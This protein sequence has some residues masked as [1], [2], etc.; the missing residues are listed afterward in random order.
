[1]LRDTMKLGWHT[2][3]VWGVGWGHY[4]VGAITKEAVTERIGKN[5]RDLADDIE[6]ALQGNGPQT[7]DAVEG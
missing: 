7:E 4:S 1:M 3:L 5:M 6:A 2:R